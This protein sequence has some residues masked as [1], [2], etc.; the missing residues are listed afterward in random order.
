MFI[1]LNGGNVSEEMG[2]VFYGG[3][4]AVLPLQTQS[5]QQIVVCIKSKQQHTSP[6]SQQCVVP[7]L[8]VRAAGEAK[9]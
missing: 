7:H 5:E 3:A 2:Q 1:L 9:Q 8:D 6:N 4:A